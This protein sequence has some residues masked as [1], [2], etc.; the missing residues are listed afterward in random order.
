MNPFE[1]VNEY[2]EWYRISYEELPLILD[3][4]WRWYSNPHILVGAKNIIT[5]TR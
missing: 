4:P 1:R 5:F 2:M 3:Y